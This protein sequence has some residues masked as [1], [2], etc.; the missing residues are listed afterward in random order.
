MHNMQ[1]MQTAELQHLR[2]VYKKIA[3]LHGY[4]HEQIV[5]MIANN[6]DMNKEYYW[7]RR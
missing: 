1:Q 3:W 6:M 4:K 7:N 5:A 2:L